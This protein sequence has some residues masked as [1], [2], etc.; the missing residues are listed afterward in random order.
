MSVS[1]QID[2]VTKAS[3]EKREDA[4]AELA[5]G[6]HSATAPSGR[7][8]FG[9]AMLQDF[10]ESLRRWRVAAWLG[11]KDAVL[12][13]RRTY[14][15]PLWLVIQTTVWLVM[16]AVLL[17]PSL[18]Q[19]REN[20]IVYVAG[21]M[22]IFQFFTGLLVDGAASFTRDAGLIQ[23]IPNPMTLYLLRALFKSLFLFLAQVPVLIG[24]YVI[25]GVGIDWQALWA[26]PGLLLSTWVILGAGL[27]LASIT[28]RL[29]DI[30]FALN[31]AMRVLFFA[32]PIFWLMDGRGLRTLAANL[33]P[34][35]HL[36]NVVREPLLGH[37]VPVHS[38]YV[39]LACGA[40]SWVI[41]IILFSRARPHIASQL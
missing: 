41:G 13:F 28:P 8:Q 3:A 11:W 27:A 26:V 35:A 5:A 25:T 2:T 16:I 9:G 40:V 23:N 4:M 38:V 6:A 17:G 1:P 12:P 19:G 31:A 30:P 21:G 24:A 29:R 34:F 20:Y 33:N 15:G 37:P 22:I 36:L 18:G 32:T 39:C 7:G 14:F 10:S